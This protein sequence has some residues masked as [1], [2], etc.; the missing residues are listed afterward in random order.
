MGRASRTV[1]PSCR[2]DD[3]GLTDAVSPL[4]PGLGSNWS[5]PLIRAVFDCGL[6]VFTRA[7]MVSV[8]VAPWATTPTVQVRVAGSQTPAVAEGDWKITPAGSTSCTTTPVAA[9]GPLL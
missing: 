9:F 3:C 1:L 5:T 8:W 6:G 7:V 4:L 2:S